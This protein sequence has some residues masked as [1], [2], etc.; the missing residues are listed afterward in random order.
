M[1]TLICA[2]FGCSANVRKE[3]PVNEINPDPAAVVVRHI[4]GLES[5]T[6]Q[7]LDRVR[8]K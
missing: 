7:F 2:E 4:A 6:E 1:G 8:A 5:R 3:P